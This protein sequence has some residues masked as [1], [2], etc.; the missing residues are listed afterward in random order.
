MV[1]DKVAVLAFVV[2][3][4][5]IVGVAPCILKIKLVAVAAVPMFK[6]PPD[7]FGIEDTW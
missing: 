6:V 2:L 7:I 3:S 1:L 4:T 5:T